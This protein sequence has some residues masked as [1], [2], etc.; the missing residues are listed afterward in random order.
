[1]QGP[2]GLQPGRGGLV[3]VRVCLAL[4][5][6]GFT[7]VDTAADNIRIHRNYYYIIVNVT[8]HP[9][10]TVQLFFIK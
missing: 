8:L 6:G 10:L 2:N 3:Y 7:S 1:M 4:M 5:S 9:L